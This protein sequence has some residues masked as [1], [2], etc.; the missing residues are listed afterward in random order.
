MTTVNGSR[1]TRAPSGKP[2]G[3]F[4]V[5]R[6]RPHIGGIS[7][8]LKFHLLFVLKLSG[9]V[10]SEAIAGSRNSVFAVIALLIATYRMSVLGRR[11]SRWRIQNEGGSFVS[12][13][14]RVV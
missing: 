12:P 7:I 10:V 1:E 3:W 14:I 4:C 2:S 6:N 9:R 5:R 11:I 8:H 13:I